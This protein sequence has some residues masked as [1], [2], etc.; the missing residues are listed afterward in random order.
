MLQ[1]ALFGTTVQGLV[2]FQAHWR[3]ISRLL[4]AQA[5]LILVGVINIKNIGVWPEGETAKKLWSFSGPAS[6]Y[7]LA[8]D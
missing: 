5:L 8:Y 4:K 2:L 6:N 3:F 7:S 1:I